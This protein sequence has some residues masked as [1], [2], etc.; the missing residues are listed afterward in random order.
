[1]E[2]RPAIVYDP[3]YLEHAT[4]GHP[5]SG[6]RLQAI[7][8]V[9]QE[10]GA[11]SRFG[12]LTPRAATLQEL[13]TVHETDHILRVEHVAASGG[14][15]LD[16]DTFVSPGSYRAALM[17]AGAGITGVHAV[18]GGQASAVFCLVRPPGHH[19]RPRRGMGFCL[20]NNVAVAARYAQAR[21]G[22]KRILIVDF[23][24][25]HGNGTQEAFYRDEGV[26][27]FSTH[28][29]PFY[30]GTGDADET[31]EGPGEGYTINVPLG[32]GTSESEILAAYEQ[33]LA[34]AARRYKPELILVS[35]G[36]DAHWADPLTSL[37]LSITGFGRIAAI[38]KSLA[39]ELCKGRV[40][41]MLEGG[42]H[43]GALGYGVLATL[44]SMAGASVW[45]DPLGPAR[46]SAW[47]GG[48]RWF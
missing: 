31:G 41:L 15:W 45:Q 28:Q 10:T 2:R 25:H 5:E 18:L 26:L 21:H 37:G 34:P 33:V 29:F 43:L 38:V 23:D 7:L 12:Q 3:V 24:A 39:D 14:G 27:Y 6:E 4:G 32:A 19:A 36:Y 17:A 48:E 47:G 40:V 35:A 30:P 44:Q 22:L 1:M 16:P 11:A 9:L 20:F 8:R 42:Y 13:M 46:A